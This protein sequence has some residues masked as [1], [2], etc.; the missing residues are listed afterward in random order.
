M[1]KY[2]LTYNAIEYSHCAFAPL[3]GILRAQALIGAAAAVAAACDGDRATLHISRFVAQ[4]S[5]RLT[6]SACRQHTRDTRAADVNE[7]GR[8]NRDLVNSA[9]RRFQRGSRGHTRRNLSSTSNRVSEN[10]AGRL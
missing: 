6:Q 3:V 4:S 5:S 1:C 7:G 2:S 10:D 9:R 8:D